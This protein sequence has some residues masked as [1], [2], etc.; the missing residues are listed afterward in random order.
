LQFNPPKFQIIADNTG[1]AQGQ[2]R[3]GF[4]FVN[5]L[6]DAMVERSRRF[7]GG[8]HCDGPAAAVN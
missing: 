1:T 6:I 5:N 8:A 7:C 4:E 3:A 2:I